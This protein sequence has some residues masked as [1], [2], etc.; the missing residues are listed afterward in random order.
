M[1][2]K[3]TVCLASHWPCVIHNTRDNSDLS[4]YGLMDDDWGPAA[5]A[6]V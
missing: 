1:A 5:F 3:V 6:N 4:A 2:G